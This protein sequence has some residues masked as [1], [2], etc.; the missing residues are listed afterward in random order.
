MQLSETV[1]F[2]TCSGPE[3]VRYDTRRDGGYGIPNG[4]N[5]QE[6]P[7]E[8]YELGCLAQR[9]CLRSVEIDEA[10]GVR[11]SLGNR[12]DERGLRGII[13]TTQ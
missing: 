5:R 13:A 7:R 2:K 4:L 10:S 3:A 12:T 9:K 11:L 8:K 6:G 1:S